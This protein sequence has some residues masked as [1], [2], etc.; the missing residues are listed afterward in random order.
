MAHHIG[1]RTVLLGGAALILSACGT[2]DDEPTSSGSG[3]IRGR[4]PATADHAYGTTTVE[5]RPER[6]VV[7]G[8]TEQDT[9]LALG[10]T[11][12]ATTEWY[13]EQPYAVWPWAQDALGGAEPTVLSAT[14]GM[15]FEKIASLRPDLIIGTNSGVTNAD[16]DK[17]SELAPTVAAPPGA[18]DYFSPWPVQTR[19]IGDALGLRPEADRL[20]EDI[21]ARFKSEARKHP[22]LQDKSVVFLQNAVSDGSYIAY[23]PGL[24]TQFLTSLGLTIP[25]YLEEYARGEE[26]S[27]IPA[28]KIDV[29]SDADVLLWATEKASDID[30]LEDEATFMNLAPVEEGRAVYTDGTLAGAIYFTT[31]LSLPYVLDRLPGLL[32]D[33]VDGGAPREL[34]S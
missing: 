12:I 13:G 30:A 19:L 1:R 6:I 17:L 26:Q 20:I 31:P 5:S 34:A 25:G 11:P 7:V 3:S 10:H 4:F 27:Y 28:E 29:V 2:D 33:A 16:Y 23:P 22:E 8:L 32:S 15:D 18:S 14:D 9:V 24:S 21:D